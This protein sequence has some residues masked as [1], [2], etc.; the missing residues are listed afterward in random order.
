[1]IVKSLE[2]KLEETKHG[3]LLWV[4]AKPGSREFAVEGFGEWSSALEVRLKEKAER[5]KANQRL[6][7]ELEK[8]FQAETELVKGEKSRHKKVLV[9]APKKRVLETLSR[10]LKGRKA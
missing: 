5:G 1:M 4:H 7:K 2:E 8:L 6:I 10:S 9:H 3:T